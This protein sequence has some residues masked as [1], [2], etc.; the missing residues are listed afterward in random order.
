M[1]PCLNYVRSVCEDISVVD[2]Q[3]YL[4]D[5][6]WDA[7]LSGWTVDFGQYTPPTTPPNGSGD[8]CNAGFGF[9]PLALT[10]VFVSRMKKK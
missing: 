7:W 8:G 2:G 3:N 10:G 9:L 5:A 1:K 6:D 4:A